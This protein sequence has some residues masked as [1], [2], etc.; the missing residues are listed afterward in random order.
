MEGAST[1]SNDH[2]KKRQTDRKTFTASNRTDW[3]KIELPRT[4]LRADKA[5]SEQQVGQAQSP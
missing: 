2:K 5:P 4:K 1:W 3:P